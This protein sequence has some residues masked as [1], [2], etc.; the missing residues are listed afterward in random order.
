MF[1]QQAA[2]TA[3]AVPAASVEAVVA[4]REWAR[5][6]S[7]FEQRKV[8]IKEEM[9]RYNHRVGTKSTF[10]DVS[11]P[12]HDTPSRQRSKSSPPPGQALSDL[13]PETKL[14][15]LSTPGGGFSTSTTESSGFSAALASVSGAQPQAD[16]P[17]GP[18]TDEPQRWPEANTAPVCQYPPDGRVLVCWLVSTQ[19]LLGS[20]N[21]HKF[22]QPFSVRLNGEDVD[23]RLKLT[24]L[25]REGRKMSGFGKCG[26]RGKVQVMMDERVPQTVGV[27][28]RVGH[29][30]FAQEW[31]PREAMQVANMLCAGRWFELTGVEW[32]FRSAQDEAGN[33]A[34]AV[35][36]TPGFE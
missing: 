36:L 8:V 9:L 25:S 5:L 27:R 15:G 13:S 30:S 11:I 2:T 19:T 35:E 7:Q 31:Q 3:A 1:G 14:S 29:G 28:I 33:L 21:Q 12:G 34:I 6:L 10:I 17:E 32:S 26:G 16:V 24:A 22:S 23:F 20:T 18:L 4:D